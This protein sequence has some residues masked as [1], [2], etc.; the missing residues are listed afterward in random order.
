[1]NVDRCIGNISKQIDDTSILEKS[2]NLEIKEGITPNHK[3]QNLYT[4]LVGGIDFKLP[5]IDGI[6]SL[7]IFLD[8]F[9]NKFNE[10]KKMANFK[11]SRKVEIYYL[12]IEQLLKMN[13][14]KNDNET[15]KTLEKYFFEED[16]F[17]AFLMKLIKLENSLFVEKFSFFTR[18]SIYYFYV[19]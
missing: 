4:D 8:Y 18:V 17:T 5:E 9:Y 6:K 2:N 12:M 15:F 3:L 16:F 10:I 7:L 19:F 14:D 13:I 1:M 11:L